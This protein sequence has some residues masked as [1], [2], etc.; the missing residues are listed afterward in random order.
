MYSESPAD[1]Q[2]RHRC[3][4]RFVVKGV[5]KVDGYV[6]RVD[7]EQ[8][9]LRASPSIEVSAIALCSEQ[10]FCN[11]I[12]H[13]LTCKISL[14]AFFCDPL[15]LA[16]LEN[17]ECT[18]TPRRLIALGKNSLAL[19]QNI[20]IQFSL[21][22]Q[23]RNQFFWCQFFIQNGLRA[24]FKNSVPGLELIQ[25]VFDHV[26]ALMLQGVFVP[27]WRIANGRASC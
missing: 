25:V 23:Q 13:C 26:F 15:M 16:F 2:V 12:L 3:S 11:E 20:V 14:G 19:R 5:E 10:L 7:F 8:K 24:R 27:G 17:Q 9:F 18:F 1:A 21:H 22:D 4:S 6:K